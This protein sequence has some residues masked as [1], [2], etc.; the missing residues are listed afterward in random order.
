MSTAT[1]FTGSI[2]ANYHQHLGPLLFEPYA[3]DLTARIADLKPNRI[4]EL[5][6]GTGIVTRHLADA[7]PNADIT[8]TDLNPAM[9]DVARP[10]LGPRARIRLEPV[11][12]CSLPF[13]DAAFDAI[14][15]QFGVMFFSD[16][17]R[18]MR[19]ARRV[20]AP[21]GRYIF[22]V[23]DSFAHNPI[24]RAAHEALVTLFPDNP[25]M[26]LARTPYGWSDPAEIERV[27]RAGGFKNVTIEPVEFA[28]AAPT[29]RDAATG[30]VLGTPVFAALT[31]RGLK[32][33]TPTRD[34]VAADLAKQFGDA[35]CRSRM[36][37]LVVTAW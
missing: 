5:A 1:A 36:Q 10:F 18:S 26:F 32:D 29:A 25:P 11:D 6:A 24:P 7:L 23:W 34:A 15:A 20:L 16:K 27:V 9:L 21:G 35:P 37:A 30:L 14:V 8:A 33:L 4:L 13:A 22:N 17:E 2:P 12:A 19:D 3:R 31:E 28:S